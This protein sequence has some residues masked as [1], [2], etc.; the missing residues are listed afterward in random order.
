MKDVRLPLRKA[1]TAALA[2]LTVGGAAIPVFYQQAPPDVA[3]YVL[4]T[5]P[6]NVGG[7]TKSSFDPEPSVRLTIE[8]TGEGANS[9]VTAAQIA[10][11]ILAILLPT[12]QSK[13]TLDDDIQMV[14]MSLV[15]DAENEFIKTDTF[16]YIQ[17]VLTFR[18]KLKI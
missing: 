16:Y 12:P 11:A 7:G 14:S 4:M 3:K 17:R 15:D 1:Y 9:G 13:L 2:G 8:T 10:G 6:S 18:H 5:I